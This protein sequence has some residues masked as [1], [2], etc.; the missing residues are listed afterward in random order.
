MN[1]SLVRGNSSYSALAVFKHM[2]HLVIGV[3]LLAAY[4][5]AILWLGQSIGYL[6]VVLLAGVPL[7]IAIELAFARQ[8]PTE[9]LRGLKKLQRMFLWYSGMAI[10]ALAGLLGFGIGYQWWSPSPVISVSL[11]QYFI[12]PFEYVGRFES[13]YRNYFVSC[14]AALA[15][16]CMDGNLL[17]DREIK[18]LPMRSTVALA[19]YTVTVVLCFILDFMFTSHR[20][21]TGSFAALLNLNALI[22][23]ILWISWWNLR[24]R[25]NALYVIAW[26]TL[27]ISWLFWFAHPIRTF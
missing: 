7:G 1:P 26:N 11:Y 24:Y 15:Y 4:V 6:D 19:Y 21:E 16:I 8:P 12:A 25:C 23:A 3:L 9:R 13:P 27:L 22:V 18:R 5:G 14:F 20:T 2:R 17:R 10:C